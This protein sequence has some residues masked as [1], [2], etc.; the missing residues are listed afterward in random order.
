MF[1]HFTVVHIDAGGAA[2]IKHCYCVTNINLVIIVNNKWCVSLFETSFERKEDSVTVT[3]QDFSNSL[4]SPSAFNN[5]S[6]EIL[7]SSES[8]TDLNHYC[9]SL[10]DK[11]QH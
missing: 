1:Q 11:R 6:D 3:V 2:C 4:I 8:T 7:Y 10:G 5:T 9:V